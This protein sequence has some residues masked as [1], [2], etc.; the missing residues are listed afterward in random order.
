MNVL[1]YITPLLAFLPGVVIVRLVARKTKVLLST[2][3]TI[4]IGSILWNYI[5]IVPSL[6]LG[7]FTSYILY[8]FYIVTCVGLVLL[9]YAF[10]RVVVK[11]N[12]DR[13]KHEVIGKLLHFTK[14]NYPFFLCLF[15]MLLFIVIIS[16]YHPLFLEFDAMS[17]YLPNARSI[18]HTAS[19]RTNPYHLS[20]IISVKCTAVSIL[21]SWIIL[22]S[23]G[24]YFQL[25]PISYFILTTL[26]VFL[27][28]KKISGGQASFIAVI[29]F[30]SMWSVIKTFARFTLYPDIAL[31]FYV[32]VAIFFFIKG[33]EGDQPFWYLF[34]GTAASLAIL[35]SDIGWIFY[36]MLLAIFPL[37]FDPKL[38][39]AIFLL[40]APILYNFYF[41]YDLVQFPSDYYLAIIYR[42]LPVIVLYPLLYY[43]SKFEFRKTDLAKKSLIMF[44]V[45]A[46]L[47][48]P[49]YIHNLLYH[50]IITETLWFSWMD[51]IVARAYYFYTSVHQ[52]QLGLFANSV[53]DYF[54]WNTIFTS[55]AFGALYLVPITGGFFS[56]L[57][58]C[59]QKDH[60]SSI[61][62]IWFIIFLVMWSVHFKC[63][64]QTAQIR[65]AY[66]MAPLFAVITAEGVRLFSKFIRVT[67]YTFYS[68]I[69]YNTFILAYMRKYIESSKNTFSL[70]SSDLSLVD[71]SIL[72]LAFLLSFS[73]PSLL[74]YVKHHK[75][76][77]YR[78]LIQ[79]RDVANIK[80]VKLMLQLLIIA[81]T[82][83]I[84]FSYYTSP[85]LLYVD[86]YG[87]NPEYY[88]TLDF[89]SRISKKYIAEVGLETLLALE[90]NVS[91]ITEYFNHFVKD[92]Y[93]TIGFYNAR[94]LAYW[95]NRTFIDLNWPYG[96]QSVLHILQEDN[97]SKLIQKLY[98]SN[99][100]YFLIPKSEPVGHYKGWAALREGW[101]CYKCLLNK[102]LLFKEINANKYFI[103]VKEFKFYYLYRLFSP[104]EY[105]TSLL[106]EASAEDIKLTNRLTSNITHHDGVV[107]LHA[108]ASQDVYEWHGV[109]LPLYLKPTEEYVTLIV[110]YSM[111]GIHRSEVYNIELWSVKDDKRDSILISIPLE[112]STVPRGL[113]I[114]IR[115]DVF[116]EPRFIYFFIRTEALGQYTLNLYYVGFLELT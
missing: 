83:I 26:V 63:A 43:A 72:T 42:Q 7:L 15:N 81:N 23:G 57:R 116:Y 89:A 36:V 114:K 4:L 99:I 35:T 56:V 55:A 38:G 73:T 87:W 28:S 94:L 17:T 34:S 82:Q 52:L 71:V 70:F 30:V 111:N 3:E 96:Y 58:K 37:F 110:K 69:V 78:F 13:F 49:L 12:K 115:G 31:T 112:Y 79:G 47:L 61:L 80:R 77:V 60:S 10:L 84:L 40:L 1:P 8:Y 22:I 6:I 100:R 45:P 68:F 103:P 76:K 32:S 91:E 104:Y 11:L 85:V 5:M 20:S 18:L 74:I 108:I 33:V 75:S 29:T 97:S 48:S 51:S 41:V 92:N 109:R 44:L 2:L 46:F 105:Y 107:T 98:E 113:M 9:I 90:G 93:A 65:K 24:C 59:N 101:E 21:Y 25:L 64:Y 54:H 14:E 16:V 62:L 53:A 27:L 50:H 39:K 88:T 106:Y 95:T 19:L 67:K 102:T 66:F 86:K